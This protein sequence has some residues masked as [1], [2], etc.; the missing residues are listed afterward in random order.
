M[1]VQLA[2]TPVDGEQLDI[3]NEVAD[4]QTVLGSLH[5]E[6]F[7]AACVLDAAKHE[8]WVNPNRVSKILHDKFG[9]INA[10]WFSAQWAPACGSNG[11]LDKT[12]VWVAIDGT[13]S[14]GNGGKT[15]RLR[16]LRRD[17]SA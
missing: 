12:D 2:A 15:V 13:H 5:K 9:E 4:T 6:D 3:L 10:R 8:G 11:F 14:K 7:R 17:V 1:S 16:R